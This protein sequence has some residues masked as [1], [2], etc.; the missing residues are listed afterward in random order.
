MFNIA[1]FIPI[2]IHLE[3]DIK[4]FMDLNLEFFNDDQLL[5]IVIISLQKHPRKGLNKGGEAVSYNTNTNK[6]NKE[7][8]CLSCKCLGCADLWLV[9]PPI[10][11]SLPCPYRVPTF[12]F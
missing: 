1:K 10:A 12:I 3:F 9:A 4:N 8:A 5:L 2:C 11:G 7:K 6:R